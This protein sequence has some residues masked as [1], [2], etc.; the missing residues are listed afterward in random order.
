MNAVRRIVFCSSVVIGAAFAPAAIASADVAVPFQIDPAS[1]GNPNGSFDVPPIRCATVVGDRPG[2]VTVTG[3]KEDRWGCPPV[4]EVRWLNLSTGASGV[5]WLS[6]G[7]DGFVPEAS[8]E[9]GTGQVALV[10]LVSG[11]VV[12]PGFT[13]LA[14]P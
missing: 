12:T 5:T 3:A 1:F 11:G 4:S 2:T 6:P 10:V 7:L 13:T 9:S 8:I 14:V